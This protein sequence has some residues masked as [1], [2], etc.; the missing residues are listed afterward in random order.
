[1]KELASLAH[2]GVH[3][4]VKMDCVQW[5]WKLVALPRHPIFVVINVLDLVVRNLAHATPVL[6]PVV[7]IFVVD[8][9]EDAFVGLTTAI[10]RMVKKATL[11]VKNEL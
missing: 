10:V 1:L 4:A 3:A 6:L 11:S 8:A 9:L 7:T 5:P 2:T